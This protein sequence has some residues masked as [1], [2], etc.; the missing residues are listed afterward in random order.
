M[1]SRQHP[2]SFGIERGRWLGDWPCLLHPPGQAEAALL[3]HSF[4]TTPK[5]G[6]ESERRIH[7]HWGEGRPLCEV[8][9]ALPMSPEEDYKMVQIRNP[10]GAGTFLEL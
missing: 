10:W 6:E 3:P 1:R 4:H 5:K 8:R 2:L 9:L 7:G